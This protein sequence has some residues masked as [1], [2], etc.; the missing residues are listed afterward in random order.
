MRPIYTTHMSGMDV[1]ALN[2]S[3]LVKIYTVPTKFYIRII[4]YL[5]KNYFKN[6][7]SI[8]LRNN[9][10]LDQKYNTYLLS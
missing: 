4:I 2:R 1:G 10:L 7:L 5:D 6:Y 8:R 3:L 9:I